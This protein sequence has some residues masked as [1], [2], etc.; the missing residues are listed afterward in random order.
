MARAA[1]IPTVVDVEKVRDGTHDPGRALA[2]VAAEYHAPLVAVTRGEEGSLAL[3]GGREVR[4][5]AFRV[6]CV[7]STGAGDAFHGGLPTPA[8]V[9]AMLLSGPRS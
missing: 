2:A 9:D 1:G 4:T 3:C 5:P 7:D 8:V 6:T